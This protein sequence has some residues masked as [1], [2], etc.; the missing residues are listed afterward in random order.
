MIREHDLGDESAP[1]LEAITH[2][3]GQLQPGDMV[4]GYDLNQL[5]TH[6]DLVHD[7]NLRPFLKK[8]KMPDVIVV[9]KH[10]ERRRRTRRKWKLKTL[11]KERE[12]SVDKQM[13]DRER[14]DNELFMRELEEDFELRARIKLYK[15]PKYDAVEDAMSGNEDEVP[16]IPDEELIDEMD[17]LKLDVDQEDEDEDIDL[18]MKNGQ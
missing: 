11:A 17:E 10:Y 12:Y 2:L 4:K 9:K 6:S 18:N 13:A 7:K 1:V 3:G 15:D 8:H 16:E 14:R 5:V